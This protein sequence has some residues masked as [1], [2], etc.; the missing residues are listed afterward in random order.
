M[1]VWVGPSAFA[2]TIL[3]CLK[4]LHSYQPNVLRFHAQS[5][6]QIVRGAF[7]FF[8]FFF[9]SENGQ[10]ECEILQNLKNLKLKQIFH[11][12]VVQK[13]S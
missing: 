1:R 13:F 4:E 12:L 6:R 8:F 2:D 11:I 9:K 3:M 10:K 5:I 7:F